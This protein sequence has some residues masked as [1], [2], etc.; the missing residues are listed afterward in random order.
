MQRNVRTFQA[1][2]EGV[3]FAEILA[4]PKREMGAVIRPFRPGKGSL[5]QGA[6]RCPSCGSEKGPAA[7]PPGPGAYT[8]VTPGP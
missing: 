8:S 3:L 7:V 4:T 2:I 1:L 6:V 5:E